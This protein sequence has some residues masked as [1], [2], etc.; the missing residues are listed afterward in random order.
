MPQDM[1]VPRSSAGRAAA[2]TQ[3]NPQAVSSKAGIPSA[4]QSIK[5]APNDRAVLV[6]GV[7]ENEWD[8]RGEEGFDVRYSAYPAEMSFQ[9]IWWLV[10]SGVTIIRGVTHWMPLPEAPQ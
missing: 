3:S 1:G 8:E 5:T 9:H 4:W 2:A 6:W 10:G 7:E